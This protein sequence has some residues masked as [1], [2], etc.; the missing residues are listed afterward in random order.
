[1][2]LAAAGLVGLAAGAALA[3]IG[4]KL[5]RFDA[6]PAGIFYTPNGYIGAALSALL[7]GRLAYRFVVLYP[8]LQAAQA[9]GDN[10]LDAFQRSPFTLA[11]LAIVIGYYLAYYAG[12]LIRSSALP[13][14]PGIA[15]AA[16]AA[17]PPSGP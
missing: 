1:M 10:P 11:L 15:Q 3:Y 9:G 6:M 4:V 16:D 8:T 13:E 2:D 17:S 7:L 5:T 14:Q 12:L